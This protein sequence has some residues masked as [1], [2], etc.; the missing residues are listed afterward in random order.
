[1]YSA[2]QR[3]DPNALLK[4]ARREARGCLRVFLGAAPG[5]GKTYTMLRTA[6]ERAEEGD[7]IVIG[8]V[9]SH[10]RA[11]TEALCEGLSRISLAPLQ[12]HGRTL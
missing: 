3:P 5:V 2:D 11:D 12:H 8:V 6:R 9:E 7:D 1:M 10:G 4:A